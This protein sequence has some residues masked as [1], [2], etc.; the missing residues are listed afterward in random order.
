MIHVRGLICV[1]ALAGVGFL[2]AL[3]ARMPDTAAAAAVPTATPRPASTARPTSTPRPASTP[4]PTATPRPATSRA[5][6]PPPTAPPARAPLAAAAPTAAPTP[7]PDLDWDTVHGLPS[8]DGSIVAAYYYPWYDMTTWSTGITPDQPVQP[9]RSAD[10]TVMEQQIVQAQSVGID[11]FN[12]AWLGPNNP[13]DTNLTTMLPI[14]DA[15]GFAMTVG[16]ETD[17][18]FFHSRADITKALHYA[19]AVYSGQP[20]YLRYEGKPVFFFWR[21]RA[22]PL[23]G[24]ASAVDAWQAVRDEVDPNRDAIWIGEGDRFEFLQ[25]FDG[26]YPYSIAWSGN[27]AGTLKTYAARTRAQGVSLGTDKIWVATVMPGYDDHTTGRKDAFSRDRV[28]GAF[29]DESWRAAL[30]SNPDWIMITS[31]NEWVEGSQI[32]PSRSYGNLYLNT[33]GNYSFGWKGIV[34]APPDGMLAAEIDASDTQ[35]AFASTLDQDL[36]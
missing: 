17:S 18:P 25:V 28:N 2:G 8:R 10:S 16:F 11:V 14:A 9:Y 31:W 33:T 29:Y 27:V 35:L 4:R 30:G 32:E 24:A 19:M 22:I 7:V 23:G 21:L 6:R 12:L 34:Q 36:E 26:I 3:F 5:L 1:L 20:G 13:T 15:H